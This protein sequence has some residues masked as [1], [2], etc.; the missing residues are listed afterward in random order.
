MKDSM[1]KTILTI[2]ITAASSSLLS[3]LLIREMNFVL[4]REDIIKNDLITLVESHLLIDGNY[5][6]LKKI[7]RRQIEDYIIHRKSESKFDRDFGRLAKLIVDYY[8]KIDEEIPSDAS[9]WV[10]D[11]L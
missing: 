3:F 10:F 11:R 4:D 5:D 6:E 9:G 2:I 1:K 7:K 8:K